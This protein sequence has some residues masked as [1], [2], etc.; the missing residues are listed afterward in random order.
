MAKRQLPSPEVLR[1]LLRYEAETGKLF[2]Q[3]RPASM[4]EDGKHSAAHNA[5]AWNA[6]YAGSEAFIAIDSH[7]YHRGSIFNRLYRAHRVIWAMVYGAW[8]SEL[9]DHLDRNKLNNRISN[10]RDATP[11]TNARNVGC[12]GITFRKSE[13]RW[14]AKIKV[15]GKKLHLGLFDREEDALEAY[16]LGKIEHHGDDFF[17]AEGRE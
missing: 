15:D 11:R 1:Q 6:R 9:V 5:A 10:L 13:G 3:E 17:V 8:P 7:G 2:W 4:F 14:A 12:R 16:K